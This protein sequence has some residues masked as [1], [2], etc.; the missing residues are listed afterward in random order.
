MVIKKFVNPYI[1]VSLIGVILAIVGLSIYAQ[2]QHNNIQTPI[3]VYRELTEAEEA[4]VKENIKT[5]AQQQK[6]KAE[7]KKDNPQS[8]VD[9]TSIQYDTS[10]KLSEHIPTDTVATKKNVSDIE[11]F[12]QQHLQKDSSQLSNVSSFDPKNLPNSLQP[13]GDKLGNFDTIQISSE[14]DLQ[15]VIAEMKK[16]DDPRL[17]PM[18]QM[19]KTS[20]MSGNKRIT[21]RTVVPQ[22]K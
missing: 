15:K 3:K 10:D 7:Q 21:V 20:N 1:A 4:I 13:F 22:D 11:S 16:N 12:K 18:L 5:L 9:D 8:S 14:E 17:K 19:L 6:Q 2:Y